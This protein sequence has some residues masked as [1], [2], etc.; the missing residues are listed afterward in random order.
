MT[1]M[2]PPGW[3]LAA[4]VL[5]AVFGVLAVV[6]INKTPQG[7]DKHYAYFFAGLMAGIGGGQ[8]G[9][10]IA[11]T[12]LYEPG[13]TYDWNHSWTGMYIVGE[14]TLIIMALATTIA[15]LDK[16]PSAWPRLEF[17]LQGSAC[18]YL[19]SLVCNQLAALGPQAQQHDILAFG[20]FIFGATTL[21]L[22]ITA[23]GYLSM[24]TERRFFAKPATANDNKSEKPEKIDMIKRLD[25]TK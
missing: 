15:R 2:P 14:I 13:S 20:K 8:L 24:W 12:N 21:V 1:V 18:A 23:A 11:Y 6:V 22:L 19:T 3:T 7:H 4:A 17:T 10:L 5:V 16:F 25:S 9:L